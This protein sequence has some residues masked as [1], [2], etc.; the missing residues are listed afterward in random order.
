M[1]SASITRRKE[2]PNLSKRKS[3]KAWKEPLLEELTD[4]PNYEKSEGVDYL[5]P[6]AVV[7]T[8]TGMVNV[9]QALVQRVQPDASPVEIGNDGDDN[10]EYT[11]PKTPTF[12]TS[13]RSVTVKLKSGKDSRVEVIES[14][15]IHDP[16]V[17]EPRTN[18]AGEIADA[19][20]G[21][22]ID[23]PRSRPW[24]TVKRTHCAYCAGPMPR[25]VVSDVKYQCEFDPNATEIELALI[26][27]APYW[28]SRW[29]GDFRWGEVRYVLGAD[30][31]CRH[32]AGCRCGS[33]GCKCSGC[34]LRWQALNGHERNVGNPRKV[35]SDECARLRGNELKRWKAAVERA[36]KRGESLP[37]EPED[38][39][40]KFVQRNGLVSSI[41]G[42]GRRYVTATKGLLE[43]A[44]VFRNS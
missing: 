19:G 15:Q 33:R 44:E 21:F 5:Q 38:K 8:D 31:P 34:T 2:R 24:K 25:P 35:C 14:G 39:G 40:M 18:P 11:K 32:V 27:E 22:T 30:V 7:D 13:G 16:I 10:P 29:A 43:A 4:N 6:E 1:S 23:N 26:G 12:T 3:R 37:P 28:Q 17:I 41:E 42:N 9:D 36:R 20:H